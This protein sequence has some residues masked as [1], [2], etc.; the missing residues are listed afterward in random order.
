MFSPKQ[1]SLHTFLHKITERQAAIAS[2]KQNNK[3]SKKYTV[4]AYNYH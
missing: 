1:N 3:N 4:L 2:T